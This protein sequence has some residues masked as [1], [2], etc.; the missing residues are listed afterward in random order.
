MKTQLLRKKPADGNAL[1]ITML[2]TATA[3]LTLS[4]IMS[5]SSGDARIS[6]HS[7]QYASCVMASEAGTEKAVG[8][9][10]SDFQNGG[11]ALVVANLSK[12]ATNVPS[13]SDSSYWSTWQF[14]DGQGNNGRTLI[15]RVA[16][17]NYIVLSGLYSG[18]F[19]YIS[20]Y[21]IISD[22]S[23]TN[24]M[25]SVSAGNVETVQLTRI[26]IF[27]FML[28]SSEDLEVGCTQ[29]FGVGGTVHANGTLYSEPD[30]VLVYDKAVTTVG[31]IV[32]GRSP[33]DSRGAITGI[34]A[35]LDATTAG[36]APL[37][38]PV[39]TNNSPTAIQQI[40]MPPPNGED[41]LSAIGRSRYYNQVDMVVTVTSSNTTASSGC[42]NSFATSIP[43]NQVALFACTTNSFY[44]QRESKTIQPVDIDV[45][46]LT[47]WSATNTNLR[48]ALGGR[49]L[50]SVYFWDKRTLG[51]GKLGAVRLKNGAQL[52]SLGLTVATALP[53]YIQGIYN[54]TNPAFYASAT[55]SLP[56]SIAADAVTV[57][58]SAWVDTNSTKALSSRP[59]ATNTIVEAAILAGAVYSTNGYYSGGMENF[60]RLLEDWSASTM[61]YNGSLIKMFPSQY[62]T[63]RWPG[64]GTVYNY[65]ANNHYYWNLTYA[66]PTGIPP[67]TPSLDTITLTQWQTLAPGT[68]NTAAAAF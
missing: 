36:V 54:Q 25:L 15:Q 31:Q 22:A 58:S 4:W 32:L 35:F 44:D 43:S 33:Q 12:Y 66:S 63:S 45:G 55:G 16:S 8:Q 10:W 62:A 20:Q 14:S 50:A 28:Y 39:G 51:A 23:Q 49:D 27:Q 59:A 18:L 56:A 1:V 11:E 67:L 52:P 9:L 29:P 3:L 30:S 37:N 6:T 64:P 34:S 68:T 38:L 41:P 24:G 19:G 61:W 42:F 47:S 40:I 46:A 21:Q 65:P 60:I 17:S 53:V 48:T 13:A 57:L 26:P 7:Q 5:W 2:L